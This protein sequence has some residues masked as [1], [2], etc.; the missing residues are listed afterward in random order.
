MGA[1]VIL[2]TAG[3]GKTRHLVY[4]SIKQTKNRILITTYTQANE[5]EIRKKFIEVNKC[6]PSNVTVL[7]WFSFLLKH[8]V[9]PFQPLLSEKRINGLLLVNSQRESGVK[10]IDKRGI[11]IPY[12]ETKEFERHYFTIH[13]RK[14]FSDKLS[15]FVCRCNA[16]SSGA[17]FSRIIRVF[18]TI[19]IDEVQDLAGFDLDFIEGLYK[20]GANIVMVGD[21]RQ[22]TYS[23]NTTSKNKQFRKSDIVRF[24]EERAEHISIDDSSLITNYRCTKL[25]CDLSNKLFPDYPQAI[26]G[27]HHVVDHLGVFFLKTDDVE[28]YLNTFHP[29]QLR[30]SVKTK[31]N[32]AYQV[33]NFGE[34]KGLSFDRALIYPTSPIIQWL[35][36]H[37]TDLAPIS[38]AKFYVA[39]TRARF[40][41]AII[42]DFQESTR[43]DGISNFSF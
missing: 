13:N 33:M 37:S 23:T 8:G 4:E 41:V 26:S 25:I 38:R 28:E 7:S 3:S 16:K 10:F 42:Y 21:P 17:V 43:V 11:A 30:D 36:D 19:Y 27:N 39:L 2:A 14:I 40:S 6:I 5:L 35:F 18:P 9:R 22:A 24:F 12:S 20:N 1:R 31:V 34:S 29:V 15:K 32:A